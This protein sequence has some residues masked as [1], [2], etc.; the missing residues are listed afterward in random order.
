M[1]RQLTAS[2][3]YIITNEFLFYRDLFNLIFGIISNVFILLVF[4]NLKIFRSNQ[5]AFYI[6]V[7]SL[8]N[9]GLILINSSNI[10]SYILNQELTYVSLVWCKLRITLSQDFGLISLYTICFSAF[11]QYLSTSYRYSFRQLSTLKLAHRL[12]IFTV[13][14]WILHNILFLI[15]NEIYSIFTC[16]VYNSIVKQYLT[17]FYYPILNTGIPFVVAGSFSLLAYRNVPRIIRRQI[18][19]V[20]RRLEQQ[21]TAMVLT[22]VLCLTIFG[23]P[24]I[25]NS[26]YQLNLAYTRDNFMETAIATLVSAVVSTF[27]YGNFSVN[28][29]FLFI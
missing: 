13:C 9:I 3:I 21:L 28:F 5:F 23:L 14:F 20:H 7:E 17:F 29:L 24:Y 22:R 19:I 18:P 11:H 26:I 8:A 27:L 12:I 2:D 16:T 1:L 4:T 25:I 10:I 15:F 6:K